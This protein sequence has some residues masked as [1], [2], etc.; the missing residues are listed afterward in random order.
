LNQGRINVETQEFGSER[1]PDLFILDLRLSKRFELGR[2]GHIEI[3][4]DGFNV[5]N[6]VTTLDWD[7]ESWSGYQEIWEVLAPRILRFGV[8]WGF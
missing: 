5:L 6:S 8:K 1:Y 7:E 3:M 2:F 4:L